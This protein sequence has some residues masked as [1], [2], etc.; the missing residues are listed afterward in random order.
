M[1]DTSL[2]ASQRGTNDRQTA[3]EQGILGVSSL[4]APAA[5]A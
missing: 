3:I 4:Y 2:K 1:R 5:K